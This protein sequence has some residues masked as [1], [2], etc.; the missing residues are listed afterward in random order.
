MAN[1]SGGGSKKGRP[2][3]PRS[4]DS[5]PKSCKTEGGRAQQL[6]LWD[7]SWTECSHSVLVSHTRLV[8][9]PTPLIGLQP[10][11]TEPKLPI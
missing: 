2:H 1:K 7:I 6:P 3:K 4:V 11:S 8:L 5:L 9:W 10:L